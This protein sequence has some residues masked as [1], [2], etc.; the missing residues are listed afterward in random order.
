MTKASHVILSHLVLTPWLAGTCLRRRRSLVQL[1]LDAN[2]DLALGGLPLASKLS[3][4]GTNTPFLPSLI[5]DEETSQTSLSSFLSNHTFPCILKPIFGNRSRGVQKVHSLADISS[6]AGEQP[7]MLQPFVAAPNEY[8]INLARVGSDVKIYGLTEIN[9]PAVWGNGQSTLV[10]LAETKYGPDIPYELPDPQSIPSENQYVPLQVAR[11][12][13]KGSSYRDI[14]GRVTSKLQA[15]CSEA[16]HQIGLHF[17]RF[18]V[19]ADSLDALQ[20]GDFYIM[21]TNGSFSLD[22]TIHDNRHSLAT[23]TRRL[24]AHWKRFFQQATSHQSS[25]CSNIRLLYHLLWFMVSPKR[26][27][28]FWDEVDD[29]ERAPAC[30]RNEERL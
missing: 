25:E 9:L 5:I 18:D 23:K 22:L 1:L 16:A 26:A 6:H 3:R 30:G 27:I 11:K 20:Q 28:S 8:G 24:R 14:T 12:H 2:P 29:W 19:K 21:E 17:G 4:Y 7:M 15:V 13:G 10:D